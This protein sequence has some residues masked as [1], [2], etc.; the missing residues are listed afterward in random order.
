M[1]LD[2]GKLFPIATAQNTVDRI[3]AKIATKWQTVFLCYALLALLTFPI[4][5]ICVFGENAPQFA[6]DA[7]DQTAARL[8]AVAADWNQYGLTLWNPY[9]TAGDPLLS[10]FVM[11]PF[12][13]D[14]LLS[15]FVSPFTAYSLTYYLIVL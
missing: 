4:L 9:L 5:E 13:V 8:G 1:D 15:L 14:V 10:Q 3:L 7:F 6:H 2:K 11:S 12:S